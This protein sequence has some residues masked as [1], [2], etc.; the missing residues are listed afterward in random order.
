MSETKK[1]RIPTEELKIVQKKKK[2]EKIPQESETEGE[3]VI[4]Q[5]YLS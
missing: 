3:T 1:N 2:T 5:G 4:S